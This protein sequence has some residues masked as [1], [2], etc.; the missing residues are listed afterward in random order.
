LR[1]I[2]HCPEDGFIG[3]C[4]RASIC[5][6]LVISDENVPHFAEH[7]KWKQALYEWLYRKGYTLAC[8]CDPEDI[9]KILHNDDDYL[10]VGGISPRFPDEGHMVVYKNGHMVHDPHPSGEGILGIREV[11]KLVP[12]EDDRLMAEQFLQRIRGEEE[13]DDE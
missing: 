11:C 7:I 10:L 8:W 13:A 9:D 12:I 1:E 5:S 3:D 6:V 4:L 2:Q